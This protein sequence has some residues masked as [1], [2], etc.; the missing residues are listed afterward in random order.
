MIVD[1]STVIRGLVGRIVDAEPDMEVAASAPN[2]RIA[3]DVLRH[4]EVDV[5]LLDIEMPEM[6]GLTALP[7]MLRQNPGVRV[8]M[9]SSLTRC[10][11]EI[12][13]RCLSLGAAEYVGKPCAGSAI[14]GIRE[15][16]REVVTKIRALG[17]RVNGAHPAGIADSG[18]QPIAASPS[19]MALDRGEGVQ[20]IAVAASTGGPNALVQL[21]RGLP[22]DLCVPV[23]IT[24]HMPPIFTAALA[25]RLTRESGRACSEARHGEPL[26]PGRVYLAP[27][28]HHMSIST[29]ERQP[30]L[31]LDR[32]PPVNFCRPAADPMF[33]SVA[34]LYGSAAL[35]VVLTGMG[36][37]GMRG[38]RDIVAR[39]GRVV[40]QD[41]ATS[42][43]WGMPGAVAS[44]GLASAVL[45]IEGIARHLEAL[46]GARA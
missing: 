15:V 28:D 39:G 34:A 23:V 36:D 6:D 38:C 4:R 19:L 13:L 5:V 24:Q 8:M 26:L 18:R 17:R 14:Q 21:L 30:H 29:S 37:D 3:L 27:G 42:V 44:A 9:M 2:G 46:C 43:V 45:P 41:Q 1:D 33:Q 31:R 35:A 7:L 12:T 25:E 32:G 20:I 16:S 11:A 40:V 10:G 22:H